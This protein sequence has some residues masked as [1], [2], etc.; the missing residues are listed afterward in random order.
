MTAFAPHD[1]GPVYIYNGR[2]NLRELE[3]VN[4]TGVRLYFNGPYDARDLRDV[5]LRGAT[6]L[7]NGENV[8]AAATSEIDHRNIQRTETPAGSARTDQ[9]RRHTDRW[10]PLDSYR[11]GR[12]RTGDK[13]SLLTELPVPQSTSTSKEDRHTLVE[14]DAYGKRQVPGITAAGY[15]QK[16]PRAAITLT[17][18]TPIEKAY[19]RD[20]VN[21]TDDKQEMFPPTHYLVPEGQMTC[22]LPKPPAYRNLPRTKIQPYVSV[23][24]PVKYYTSKYHRAPSQKPDLDGENYKNDPARLSPPHFFLPSQE[25]MLETNNTRKRSNSNTIT[26]SEKRLKG[27]LLR[28]VRVIGRCKPLGRET[29]GGHAGN[30]DMAHE[31][32]DKFVRAKSEYARSEAEIRR[33]R[34]QHGRA[35]TAAVESLMLSGKTLA[36]L[37]EKQGM[38]TFKTAVEVEIE[39]DDSAM[40]KVEEP[41][42]GEV[43]AAP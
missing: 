25:P 36:D 5:N 12:G 6:I 23:S 20:Q 35:S 1:H 15:L 17:N 29:L 8:D 40:V 43:E 31:T 9:P 41:V 22:P 3:N 39:A 33:Q 37:Y 19:Y 34:E 26:P 7:F 32:R 2:A 14:V 18:P 10:R 24:P 13:S 27:E 16:I 11:P 38:G 21:R 4:L 30:T 42:D 28:H